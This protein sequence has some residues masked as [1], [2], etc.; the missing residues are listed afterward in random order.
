MTQSLANKLLIL[1]FIALNY[2]GI[3]I[4][5]SKG[6]N[7]NMLKKY[8]WVK[9]LISSLMIGLLLFPSFGLCK[10]E[11]KDLIKVSVDPR[12]EL[13][14]IIDAVS[15]ADRYHNCQLMNTI[16]RQQA[17]RH[18]SSHRNHS[19]ITM[20]K[21]QIKTEYSLDF[22]EEVF[23]M[24]PLSMNI[25]EGQTDAIDD[26]VLRSFIHEAVQFYHQ[27]FVCWFLED[28]EMVISEVKRIFN[29]ML[30]R[31]TWKDDFFSMFQGTVDEVH[32][33]LSPLKYAQHQSHWIKDEA[34]SIY[35]L[36]LGLTEISNGFLIFAGAD[37]FQQ[38]L[39]QD[40]GSK[41]IAY[42][43]KQI[44]D[45][46]ETLALHLTDKEDEWQSLGFECAAS[47]VAIQAS[48]VL[49]WEFMDAFT[50][51]FDMSEKKEEAFENGYF[52]I[53]SIADLMDSWLHCT[54]DDPKH[55]SDFAPEFIDGLIDCIDSQRKG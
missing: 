37:D 29:A 44:E 52:L 4:F 6:S 22:L 46:Y 24:L 30:H 41:W 49:Y 50:D 51:T 21:D 31:Q 32:I 36:I 38:L 55:W 26:E 10:E 23:L 45:P 20:Y 27:A 12:I 2:N 11:Q 40:A 53:Y 25:D 9:G 3:V 42:E 39:L 28:M 8:R 1:F 7:I 17:M 35:Y 54:E 14:Y 5:G 16:Y 47:F 48:S 13:L 18:F 15:D 43:I 33:M 19:A 34:S